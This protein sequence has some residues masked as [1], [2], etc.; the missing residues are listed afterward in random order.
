[1]YSCALRTV[2]TVIEMDGLDLDCVTMTPAG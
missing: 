1:M 2:P